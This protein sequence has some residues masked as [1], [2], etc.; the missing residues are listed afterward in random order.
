MILATLYRTNP[1]YCCQ[2]QKRAWIAYSLRLARSLAKFDMHAPC[3]AP[4]FKG[5]MICMVS[6]HVAPRNYGISVSLAVEF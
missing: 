1:K 6:Q 4:Q 3:A 5:M 2:N